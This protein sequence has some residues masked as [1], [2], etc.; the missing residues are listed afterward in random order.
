[1]NVIWPMFYQT[2]E[3]YRI[4]AFIFLVEKIL[5]KKVVSEI[6]DK[7]FLRPGPFMTLQA[8]YSPFNESL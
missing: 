8:C 3:F 7:S 4:K 2:K 5:E 6:T 1:M